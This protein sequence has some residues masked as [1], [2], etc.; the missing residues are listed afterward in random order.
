M[1]QFPSLP[2][3]AHLSDLLVRFPKNVQPLMAYV[4]AVLRSDG[5]LSIAERELIATFV[6]GLNACN[7]C[8]G[9]HEIYARAFG[10]PAGIVEQL[11]ADVETADIDEKLKPIFSYVQKLNT[12]P[13]KMTKADAQAVFDAGWSEEALFE[14]VEV[15]GVFNLM[16]RMVEGSGVNFD[17][18]ENPGQHTIQS[19]NPEA[20]SASYL[21]FAKR[22]AGMTA[23]RNG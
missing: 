16:N 7:F 19:A 11:L 12:L 3:T 2:D 21:N 5:A 9:S 13:S 22:I 10:I 14:A 23:E 8:F 1:P 15:A 4:N 17:Y 18:S 20:L 6:S